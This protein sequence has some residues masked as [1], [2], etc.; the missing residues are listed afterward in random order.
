VRRALRAIPSSGRVRQHYGRP[1]TRAK[2]ILVRAAN[3]DDPEAQGMDMVAAG[4]EA[5]VPGV[6]EAWVT[7]IVVLLWVLLFAAAPCALLKAGLE[8]LLAPPRTTSRN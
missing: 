8:V 3:T 6:P 1:G 7:R 2:E 5:L 4:V